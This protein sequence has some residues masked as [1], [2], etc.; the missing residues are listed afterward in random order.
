MLKKRVK[1]SK[2]KIVNEKGKG[3]QNDNRSTDNPQ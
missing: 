1:K 2:R 3:A